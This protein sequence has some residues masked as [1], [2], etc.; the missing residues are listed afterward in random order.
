MATLVEYPDNVDVGLAQ[1][2]VGLREADTDAFLSVYLERY[3]TLQSLLETYINWLLTWDLPG[4]DTP[5]FILAAIG[6]LFGQPRPVGTD[7]EAYRRILI[8]RRRV[9][10][11]KGTQP[12]VRRIVQEIGSYGGGAAVAFL[13]PNTVIVTFANFAAVAAQGLTLEVVSDLLLASIGS[14][15]RLQIWDAVGNAFT[16]DIEGKGWLQAVW[17]TPLFDSEDP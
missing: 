1:L 14:V 11:S 12:D 8:V 9:R 7:R 16:W 15:K 4:T 13:V 2:P 10:R 3:N 17:A 5:D 6:K